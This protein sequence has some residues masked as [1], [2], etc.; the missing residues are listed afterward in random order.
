MSN[1][2]LLGRLNANTYW[3]SRN[4]RQEEPGNKQGHSGGAQSNLC[5]ATNTRPLVPVTRHLC[6]YK[7]FMYRNAIRNYTTPD[8][9]GP[10]QC[11]VLILTENGAIGCTKISHHFVDDTK[12]GTRYKNTN[13]QRYISTA[14]NGC[15]SFSDARN[16]TRNKRYFS[17]CPRCNQEWWLYRQTFLSSKILHISHGVQF[18]CFVCFSQINTDDI[19][20]H[21]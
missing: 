9:S 7:W 16:R 17:S 3:A 19:P 18:M 15:I 1:A 4:K 10:Q 2:I 13:L 11:S 6:C 12:Y 8:P 20:K 14:T 5:T 21:H